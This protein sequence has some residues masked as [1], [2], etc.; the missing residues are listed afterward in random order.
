MHELHLIKDLLNDLLKRAEEEQIKKI[1]RVMIKMGEFTE[2]NPE[3]LRYS[4]AQHA[5]G[6][7]AEG[8]ELV[9]EPS[10]TRELRLVS[11]DGE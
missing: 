2:I 11:F 7:I 8:A 10:Q 9:I 1:S 6:T 3:I 4:L 5:Q